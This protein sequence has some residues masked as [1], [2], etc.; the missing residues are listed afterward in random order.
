M[1]VDCAYY[2]A[3]IRHEERMS[4]G[5]AGRLAREGSGFV[6]LASSEPGPEELDELGTSFDLPPRAVEDAREDH[7]R[8]KLDQHGEGLFLVVKTLG[9]DEA[10]TRSEIGEFDVFVG[11][12]YAIVISRSTGRSLAGARERLDEHPQLAKLGPMAA[13]WA[14]L[15]AVIDDSEGVVDRLG[16]RLEQTEQA[17]FQRDRDQSEAIYLQHR[18]TERLARALHPMLAIFDTLERGEPV[19]SPEEL[20]PLFRDVGDHARHLSEEVM[21]LGEALDGLL[22]ANLARVTVRQNVIVQQVSSWAAIAAVPTIITGIYGMNFRHMPELGWPL[23]Y[24]LA[25]FI[26]VVAV[27]VLRWNFRR[28]GWL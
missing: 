16:D 5:E 11:V 8:P 19:E 3:G 2:Q 26:M 14:L 10:T 7:Q 28:V 27:L 23:G 17:V 9:Y 6:W 21:Q 13:A 15:D 20:R 18:D 25:L 4:L 12:R 22:N 1:I 24:P